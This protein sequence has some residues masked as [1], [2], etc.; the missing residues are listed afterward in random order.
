MTPEEKIAEYKRLR[1]RLVS[2]DKQ[3]TTS[4]IRIN[5]IDAERTET[6]RRIDPLIGEYL[7]TIPTGNP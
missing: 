4:L 1:D 5:V 2:I 3:H 7:K 6:M